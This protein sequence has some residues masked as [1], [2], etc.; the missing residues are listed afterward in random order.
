ARMGRTPARGTT[1][2]PHH[3][4]PYYGRRM[5]PTFVHSRDGGWVDAGWCPLRASVL[6]HHEAGLLSQPGPLR[7]SV[8]FHHEADLLS[9]PGPLRASV[10][11]HHAS[12]VQ[13][14]VPDNTSLISVKYVQRLSPLR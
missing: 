6:F 2:P 5:V 12:S 4:R 14:S 13:S 9:Q 1:P 3:S 10:L 11:F 7:A 8:L